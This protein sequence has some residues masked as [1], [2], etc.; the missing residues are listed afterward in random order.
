MAGEDRFRTGYVCFD[1]EGNKRWSA[2]TEITRSGGDRQ[3]VYT[4]TEK[5]KGYY[6]GFKG[7]VSWVAALEFESN[8]NA[9]K[10][11]RME[12]RTISE[13]GEPIAL[14]VQEFDFVNKKVTCIYEDLVKGS[15]R[16]KIFKIKG[17][18]ANRLILGLYVQKFLENGKKKQT[19]Y[20]LSG[21]PSLY[22]INIKVLDKEKININGR[23]KPAYRLCL[24]PDLGLFNV[25]KVIL[26]KAYVW[27]SAA[28]K[29]EWL[30][31]VGLE[32]S[33]SSPKVEIRTLD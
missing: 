3:D 23:E 33:V 4:L 2:E 24:D 30:K 27:H 29:F 6:S 5:G 9:V 12:R 15:K 28:P 7:K 13:E 25:L 10:P 31:Y 14:E 26:P 11:L 1:L 17:D 8:E 22:K 19:V 20:M 32:G 21:E 18:I 16:K